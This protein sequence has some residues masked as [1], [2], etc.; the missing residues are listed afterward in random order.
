MPAFDFVHASFKLSG[1]CGV[2]C[3][4]ILIQDVCVCTLY[5]PFDFKSRSYDF[6][7]ASARTSSIVTL[8]SLD[9]FARYSDDG[10]RDT[11]ERIAGKCSLR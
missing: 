6:R 5:V 8:D 11:D 7:C 2:V 1:K 10:V 9:D 4:S 3:I